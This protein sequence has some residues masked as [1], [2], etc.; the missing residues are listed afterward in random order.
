MSNKVLLT[1]EKA[2]NKV[3]TA[4][5]LMPRGGNVLFDLLFSRFIAKVVKI[6]SQAERLFDLLSVS[7]IT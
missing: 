1:R 3:K 2:V 7:F 4:A 5:R 6:F